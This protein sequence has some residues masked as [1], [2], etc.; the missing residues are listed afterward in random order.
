MILPVSLFC[1]ICIANDTLLRIRAMK[2]GLRRL[3]IKG[4]PVF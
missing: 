2:K 1:G 4:V 3:K